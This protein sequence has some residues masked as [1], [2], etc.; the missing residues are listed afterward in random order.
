M[1]RTMERELAILFVDIVDSTRLYER[2]GNVQASALTRG[3]L[4]ALTLAV[5]A[6]RGLVIK[7]L[8][9]GLLCGFERPDSA[10]AASVAMLNAQ[11]GRD[12]NIRIGLHYGSV[13]ESYEQDRLDIV[14][15]A[16]N[17]AARLQNLARPGETLATEDLVNRLSEGERRRTKPLHST[18]VK[19]RSIP[20]DIYQVR[21]RDPAEDSFE[22]TLIGA[23]IAPASRVGEPVMV[24]TYAGNETVLDHTSAKIMLGRGD[25]CDIQV[26]SMQ[27]SRQHGTIEFARDDFILTD[28][29]SNGTFFLGAGGYSTTLR[30][31]SMKIVGDGLIGLGSLPHSEDQDNVIRFKAERR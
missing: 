23:L 17:V 7:S 10:V 1:G 14:G 5:T 24:I 26:L 11:V 27:A 12:L 29:S 18:T 21:Q 2:L 30:R 28:H 3:L 6:N 4:Q 8:G 22:T 9:D 20:V 16:V 19:G 31:D 25:G 15:D 13:V